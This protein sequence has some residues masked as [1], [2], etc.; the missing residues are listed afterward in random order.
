MLK[1]ITRPGSFLLQ[2]Q[3]MYLFNWDFIYIAL[4][5]SFK[6]GKTRTGNYYTE[7]QKCTLGYHIRGQ[8]NPRY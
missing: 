3:W 1:T 8:I 7:E 4:K 6:D 5:L 2:I